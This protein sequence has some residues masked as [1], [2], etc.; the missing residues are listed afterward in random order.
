MVKEDVKK[1]LA[2][3]IKVYYP[4]KKHYLDVSM[5]EIT[6]DGKKEEKILRNDFTFL[7]VIGEGGYGKVWKV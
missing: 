4:D 2:N 7:S 6:S 1:S 3:V 5:T